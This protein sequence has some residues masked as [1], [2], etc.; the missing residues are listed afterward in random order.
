MLQHSFQWPRWHTRTLRKVDSGMQGVSLFWQCLFNNNAYILCNQR[1]H[2][3]QEAFRCALNTHSRNHSAPKNIIAY[4]AAFF[5]LQPS[6]SA[7]A[8][9]PFCVSR[10]I[11]L[12][13]WYLEA[14]LLLICFRS[15]RHNNAVPSSEQ[16]AFS[17]LCC[18][19][20]QQ[21]RVN[22]KAVNNSFL[23]F[24]DLFW[25]GGW[26]N[27]SRG[28]CAYQHI[29]TQKIAY[30]N[31]RHDLCLYLGMHVCSLHRLSCVPSPKQGLLRRPPL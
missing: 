6:S 19:A 9:F 1:S 7:G 30:A 24:S 3:K 29:N 14:F 25:L 15:C 13:K 21:S 28:K 27:R 5:S 10:F 8:G 2:N 31:S 17:C 20:T 4:T 12:M 18:C 26:Q 23:H 22:N 11:S 16:G